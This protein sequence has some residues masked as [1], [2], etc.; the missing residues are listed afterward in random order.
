MTAFFFLFPAKVTKNHRY[1]WSFPDTG[2]NGRPPPAFTGGRG[3]NH[4]INNTETKMKK[5]PEG[6]GPAPGV[7]R[8]AELS[9][10]V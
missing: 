9:C 3:T 6:L 2:Q 8:M 10:Y 4:I 1:F 7:T 5:K